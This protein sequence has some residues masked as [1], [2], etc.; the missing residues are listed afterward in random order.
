MGSFRGRVQ[1]ALAEDTD[2]PPMITFFSA[3]HALHAPVYEFHRGEPA[4]VVA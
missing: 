3:Q 2:V 1:A 4:N